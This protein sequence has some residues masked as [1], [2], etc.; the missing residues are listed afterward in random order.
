M[1]AAPSSKYAIVQLS[2]Q[3]LR[4]EFYVSA[5]RECLEICRQLEDISLDRPLTAQFIARS[6]GAFAS[7]SK[8]TGK[9]AHRFVVRVQPLKEESEEEEEEEEDTES[10]EA[11][12]RTE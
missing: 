6:L 8:P 2:C 3:G 10:E 7:T 11:Q 9:A 4:D 5:S 12:V 1:A